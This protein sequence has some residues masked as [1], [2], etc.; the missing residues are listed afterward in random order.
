MV[1]SLTRKAGFSV[2]HLSSATVSIQW[3]KKINLGRS[4]TQSA[5][6]AHYADITT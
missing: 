5:V 6:R 2:R 1:E 3:K 4:A